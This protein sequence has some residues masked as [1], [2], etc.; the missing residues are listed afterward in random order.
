MKD[1]GSYVLY[2]SFFMISIFW[3]WKYG[4]KK[5]G[6]V[7]L[8]KK[9]MY[10]LLIT[11]PIIFIQGFRYDVGTDYMSYSSLYRGFS[12]G[13]DTFYAWYANEPLF[14]FMCRIIYFVTQG[15]QYSFFIV[16]A[17]LMN[18]L[19]FITFDYYKDQVSL[20]F[21]YFFYY[22]LCF[23]YFLNIERQG[24]AVI[25]VWYATRYVHQKKFFKFLLCILIATLF[26][27]T[28]IFGAAFYFINFLRGKYSVYVKTAVALFV[29]FSPFIL[30]WGIRFLSSHV[31]LFRKY[32]KFLKTDM[33]E[34]VEYVNTNLIFMAFLILVLFLF[35]RFL[36]KSGLDMLWILFLCFAQLLA[37]VINNYIDWGFRMSFYFEFGMMYAYSF[38][39]AKLK[40][41]ANK[42]VLQSFLIVSL[43][44]YF[45][46]KFYIQGNCQII[47]YQFIWSNHL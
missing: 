21:M 41:R 6:S 47:P 43:L 16:D 38:F 42:I 15:G 11:L 9:V 39:Y 1:F 30:E 12:E 7:S 3:S 44:F 17:I 36:R 26:H 35:F 27:N 46:Y 22:L 45:T 25:I 2:L 18:V 5:N 4:Q 34:T 33:T 13:N 37:Y 31:E 29:I 40:Y 14:I 23:P 19:L 20:P 10:C 32:L 24:L 28:A 8:K